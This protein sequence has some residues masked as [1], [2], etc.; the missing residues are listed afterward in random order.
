MSCFNH[1]SLGGAQ[2]LFAEHWCQGSKACCAIWHTLGAPGQ[3]FECDSYWNTATTL[4]WF[5]LYRMWR[6]KSDEFLAFRR[7]FT[8]TSSRAASLWVRDDRDSRG[9][10]DASWCRAAGCG[11][12][13]CG[14]FL[15]EVSPKL[16]ANTTWKNGWLEDYDWLVSILGMAQTGR[17]QL[18]VSGRLKV[19]L[20]LRK[21]LIIHT[22]N[23]W[24]SRHSWSKQ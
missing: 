6:T 17:C 1:W 24:I 4:R 13:I 16:A 20:L 12:Y 2:G 7:N 8:W 3:C 18:L 10:G 19:S 23:T 5:H 9:C 22:I 21:Y 11:R 14:E 15:G